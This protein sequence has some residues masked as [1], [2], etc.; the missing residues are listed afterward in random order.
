MFAR[1]GQYRLRCFENNSAVDRNSQLARVKVNLSNAGNAALR[2][3]HMCIDP[4]TLGVHIGK[5]IFNSY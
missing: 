3:I 4:S 5:L 2:L 1:E